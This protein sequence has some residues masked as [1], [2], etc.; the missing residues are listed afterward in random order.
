MCIH[1][2]MNPVQ[3]LSLLYPIFAKKQWIPFLTHVAGGLCKFFHTSY[4]R[5][6]ESISPFYWA[7][8]KPVPAKMAYADLFEL[9]GAFL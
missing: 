3:M 1:L 8:A 4:I 7:G 9:F 5:F 6:C 2:F